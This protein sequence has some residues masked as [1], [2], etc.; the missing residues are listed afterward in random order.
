[1]SIFNQEGDQELN[2]LNNNSDYID[3][4]LLVILENFSMFHPLER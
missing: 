1:M 4:Y 2:D 3:N